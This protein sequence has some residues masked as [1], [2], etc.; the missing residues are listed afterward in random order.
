MN[1]H[2]I[3]AVSETGVT[4]GTE[5]SPQYSSLCLYM[6][7]LLRLYRTLVTVPSPEQRTTLRRCIGRDTGICPVVIYTL[8]IVSTQPGTSFSLFYVNTLYMGSKYSSQIL[9]YCKTAVEEITCCTVCAGP[10]H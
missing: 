4:K 10:K 9:I 7:L 8:Y 5:V 3:P 6:L 1:S 2:A